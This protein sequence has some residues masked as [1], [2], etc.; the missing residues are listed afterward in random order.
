MPGRQMTEF[1]EGQ[2]SEQ[3]F[4]W[5]ALVFFTTKTTKG[6]EKEKRERT[7]A[8]NNTNGFFGLFLFFINS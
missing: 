4:N 3:L 8:T 1:E 7:L 6:Y 5:T 2:R